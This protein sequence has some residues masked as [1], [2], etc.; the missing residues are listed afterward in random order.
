VIAPRLTSPYADELRLLGV[1][2][3]QE[4][5]GI[6]RLGGGT[7]GHPAWLLETAILADRNHPLLSLISPRFLRAGAQTYDELRL[8]GYTEM[9]V[10]MAQQIQQF[11]RL[12]REFAMQHFGS[13]EEMRQAMRDVLAAM[14]VEERLEGLSMR[15]VLAAVS[16]EERLE[17]LSAEQLR[18]A[19][20][21]EERLK[22]LSLEDLLKGLAPQE[23]EQLKDMLLKQTKADDNSTAK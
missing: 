16:V 7:L 10:Y 21:P 11:Q 6:W 13:E 22:G 3:L 14:P 8:A 2:A 9:V 15:D 18:E 5:E 23:L 4:S 17:G 20:P 1:T 12:G 19:L